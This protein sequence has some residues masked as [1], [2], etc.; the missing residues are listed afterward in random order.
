VRVHESEGICSVQS[1]QA[2]SQA[3]VYSLLNIKRTGSQTQSQ[4]MYQHLNHYSSADGFGADSV[5]AEP[6][7]Q[8]SQRSGNYSDIHS[9][10]AEAAPSVQQHYSQLHASADTPRKHTV[11][12]P[13]EYSRLAD[14]QEP[15]ITLIN[16]LEDPSVEWSSYEP[17]APSPYAEVRRFD[18]AYCDPRVLGEESF[19]FNGNDVHTESNALPTSSYA[20]PASLRMA[21]DEF[22]SDA[23]A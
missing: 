1:S 10:Y 4:S 2:D 9:G 21:L 12:E 15:D 23:T 19:G 16:P 18:T 3:P 8:V 5:Y 17:V 11:S 20:C 14:F 7:D 6:A 13:G 22:E